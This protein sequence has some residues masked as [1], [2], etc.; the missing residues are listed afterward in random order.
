MV[1]GNAKVVL[2]DMRTKS[3]TKGQIDEFSIGDK[4]PVLIKIPSMVVHAITPID[5]DPVYLINCPTEVYNYDNPDECRLPINTD[6]IKY[7]W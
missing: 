6:K 4:N 7:K 5:N 2:Y 3:K 1:K